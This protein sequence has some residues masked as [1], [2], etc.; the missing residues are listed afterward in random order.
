MAEVHVVLGAT[1]SAGAAI[2][3]HLLA[4]G[5]P[6]RAVNRSGDAIPDASGRQLE[7]VAAD[8]T[9][10]AQAAR[11]IH[12][13]A[14]VYMAAQPDYTRW[15]EAFPP[16][17]DAVVQASA[18]A[19]AKLVMV[20]NCYAYGRVSGPMSEDTPEAATDMKGVVRRN[21]ARGLL[22]AHDRGQLRVTIGRASD[23]VGPQVTGSLPMV[24]AIA[25]A[26]KP[27]GV[28]RWPGRTDVP[29]SLAYTPDIARSLVVLGTSPEA[30]GRIWHLPH[31]PAV[32]GAA[33]LE[34]VTAVLDTPHRTGRLRR[35]ALRLA[36]PFHPLS[37]ETLGV[38]HQWESPFVVDDSA[39]R[40]TFDVADTPLA[41]AVRTTVTAVTDGG[42]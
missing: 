35:G 3:H 14:V 23:F 30:D 5:L 40:A 20:D 4:R 6:T 19:G 27:R 36:A 13:A 24:M 10:A 22:D 33:F 25:P 28:L 17:L 26:G 29:H 34:M 42:R 16:L 41:E 39:Y 21:L 37:R 1:G 38:F 31:A 15:P 32:T 9:D 11:A 2:A 12:G 18:A 8:L 7:R